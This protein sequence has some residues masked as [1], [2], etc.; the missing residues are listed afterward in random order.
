MDRIKYFCNCLSILFILSIHVHI[1]VDKY[2]NMVIKLRSNICAVRE[3]FGADLTGFGYPSGFF[4]GLPPYKI[5]AEVA[6][7]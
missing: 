1:H 5:T 4:C 2:L 6:F 7:V 3:N